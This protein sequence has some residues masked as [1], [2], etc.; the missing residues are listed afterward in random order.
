MVALE[1]TRTNSK[2][3]HAFS[4]EVQFDRLYPTHQ[5]MADAAGDRE[6]AAM[7]RA[8]AKHEMAKHGMR[9]RLVQERSA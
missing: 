7:W 3:K 1:G 5:D 8:P 6:P 4:D 9:L 2:L